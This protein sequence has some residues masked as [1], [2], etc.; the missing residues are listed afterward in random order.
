M[1]QL[2]AT[3]IN[4]DVQ[5]YFDNL[6]TDEYVNLTFGDDTNITD[7]TLMKYLPSEM[8]NPKNNKKI[9]R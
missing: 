1:N 5:V 6:P 4:Y 2:F 3:R 8:V 7:K 9:T